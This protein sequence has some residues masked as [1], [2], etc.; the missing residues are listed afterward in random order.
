VASGEQLQ[1]DV[2]GGRANGTLDKLG[3]S[4]AGITSVLV[5]CAIMLYAVLRIAY[6]VF[7]DRY[8]LR[9][10]DLGLSYADLLAQS[11]VGIVLLLTVMFAVAACIFLFWTALIFFYVVI[12]GVAIFVTS[13]SEDQSDEQ[14]DEKLEKLEN[15]LRRRSRA[16]WRFFDAGA[17]LRGWVDVRF[18]EKRWVT[19]LF[20]LLVVLGPIALFVLYFVVLYYLPD[21][22]YEIVTD[23]L[24][25]VF[26]A[27]A[28]YVGFRV[29]RGGLRGEH[30]RRWRRGIFAAVIVVLLAAA[31]LLVGLAAYDR[32]RV[33]D[34][35]A[36]GFTV[37]GFP[38]TTWGAKDATVRWSGSISAPPDL[39]PASQCV[40]YFG[41]AN[42]TA[43]VFDHDTHT[44]LRVPADDIL[45]RTGPP[46][47]GYRTR[48]LGRS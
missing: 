16:V 26:T 37:F 9:P 14:A 2:Q 33:W 29:L 12:L 11:A 43:F 44:V 48:R 8:G 31:G 18:A 38:V 21:P 32:N 13:A 27:T 30:P 23:T 15:R 20:K 47:C 25:V 35:H 3:G 4:A 40:L 17:R 39:P 1:K 34:G 45:I 28:V 10:E 42:G 6:S 7:Y 19:R 36:A 41:E 46:V 5:V 24:A 22:A